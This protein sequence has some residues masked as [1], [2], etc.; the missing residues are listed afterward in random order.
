VN[1][2]NLLHDCD[3]QGGVEID[4]RSC[5]DDPQKMHLSHNPWERG[6][7][8]DAWIEVYAHLKFVGPL[9]VNTKEDGL[10]HRI[11]ERLRDFQVDNY[12]FLDTTP[13]TLARCI[14]L[15]WGRHMSIRLSQLEPPAVVEPWFRLAQQGDGKPT[16]GWLWIDCFGGQ[17][18]ATDTIRSFAGRL[19][20]CL[21]SPELQGQPCES[22]KQFQHLA[23]EVDAICTKNPNAWR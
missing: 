20:L 13:P 19:R 9:I 2:S 3:V 12:F 22:I 5:V 23:H 17:P 15:G 7:D 16:P 21:V 6:A 10:E 4:V 1:Q 18:L 11:V 8:L 14:N